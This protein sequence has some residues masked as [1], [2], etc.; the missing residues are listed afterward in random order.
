MD[1]VPA[2]LDPLAKVELSDDDPPA[3]RSKWLAFFNSSWAW[4]VLHG[5]LIALV[6]TSWRM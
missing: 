2:K 6:F 1:V 3:P 5:I 4:G